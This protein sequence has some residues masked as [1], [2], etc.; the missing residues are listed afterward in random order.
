MF[1]NR[2]PCDGHCLVGNE[3]QGYGQC[4]GEDKRSFMAFWLY[5]GAAGGDTVAAPP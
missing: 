5:L 1:S 2:K 4:G 3:M